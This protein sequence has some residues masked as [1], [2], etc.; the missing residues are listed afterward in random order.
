M[1]V[2]SISILI[3]VTYLL[4][5]TNAVANEENEK[6]YLIQM[7]NQLNALKPLI[8]SASN[9]Q[10]KNSR[11]QFRYTAFVNSNGKLQNGL[12][13]D[14]NELKKGIQARLNQKE[15]ESQRFEPIKGDYISHDHQSDSE[16][17]NAD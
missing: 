4:C 10:Q 14:I 9:E 5:M 11:F 15:V 16:T 8:I 6:I 1:K 17:K 13:E 7:L 12:L 2:K 3:I